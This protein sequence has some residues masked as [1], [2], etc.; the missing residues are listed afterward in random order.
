MISPRSGGIGY[1]TRHNLSL[2]IYRNKRTAHVR[3]KFSPNIN[4][5]QTEAKELKPMLKF[6]LGVLTVDAD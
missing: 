3:V 1:I 6:A 2:R 5:A 4:N